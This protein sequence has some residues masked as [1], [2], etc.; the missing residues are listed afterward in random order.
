MGG[1]GRWRLFKDEGKY[2]D[3]FGLVLALTTIS[4]SVLAL[5]DLDD[6]GENLR[7]SVGRL[8]VTF[9]VGI[10][11]LIALRASGVTR[12]WQRF[13]DIVIGLTLVAE[14][15]FELLTPFLDLAPSLNP[16]RP[17]A[18]WVAIAVLSPI[19]VLRRVLSHSAVTYE[20]LAGALSVYL[21]VAIAFSYLFLEVQR[22]GSVPFFGVEESTS[23]FMYFSL[24]TVTT[25]GYGDL[26]AVSDLG[27]YLATAEAIIGQVFLVTIVARLVSLY[28]RAPTQPELD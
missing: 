4:V 7:S 15:I 10:T 20:T 6:P 24:V 17:S 13:A 9:T 11:L 18:L 25:V 23:S 27:R 1:D 19:V 14:V 2:L 12:S 16:G 26:A 8:V 5:V 22:F 28:S 21:L 3:R